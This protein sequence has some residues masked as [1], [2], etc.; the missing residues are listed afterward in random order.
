MVDEFT[1][2]LVVTLT[3]DI[4]YGDVVIAAGTILVIEEAYAAH[5]NA[6]LAYTSTGRA[7]C[8]YGR[9]AIV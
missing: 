8:V 5:H 6:G 9:Q 7:V 2:G 3:E 1:P 4:D